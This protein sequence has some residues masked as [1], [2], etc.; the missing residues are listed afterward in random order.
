MSGQLHPPHLGGT[1][2]PELAVSVVRGEP[3]GSGKQAGF[4]L[5]TGLPG[6]ALG[7]LAKVAGREGA[8]PSGG[9]AAAEEREE[10]TS[11][12]AMA[13]KVPDLPRGV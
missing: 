9:S 13:G 8:A 12:E 10:G 6:H 4:L 3:S 11:V 1:V 2:R 7:T 5:R